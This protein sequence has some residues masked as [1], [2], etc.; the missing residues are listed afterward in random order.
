MVD[1]NNKPRRIWQI[2]LVCSLALNLAVAGMVIGTVGSGKLRDGPPRSFDLG[3]GPLARALLPQE[4]RQVGQS[5]RRDRALNGLDLNARVQR[6]ADA[7]RAEPF[8]PEVLRRLLAEQSAQMAAVQSTA[9]DALVATISAM[10]PERR[11][12]FADQMIVEMARTR[13]RQPRDGSGG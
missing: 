5:L 13:P 11:A 6:T 7:L 4:R 12:A 2:V 1:Q 10:T 3:V 8:Q 9:Q